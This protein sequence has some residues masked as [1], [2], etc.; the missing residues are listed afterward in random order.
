MELTLL[1]SVR[2]YTD[3]NGVIAFLEPHLMGREV[4]FEVHSHG[5]QLPKLL[6][7]EE[8]V[9]LNVRRGGKAVIRIRRINIAE[10]LYRLTGEGI[11]RDSV[12]LGLPVP[13]R[14]PLLNAQVMGTD[15]PITA[16]YRGKLFW[17]F[18]DTNGVNRLNLAG[19]VATSELPGRGGLDPSKG[20][21]LTFFVD[22][23]GFS[24][25][26]FPFA[27]GKELV[28]PE[29]PMALRDPGGVERLVMLY[30]RG[31]GM[32]KAFL[33]KK[34]GSVGV[35]VKDLTTGAETA[36]ASVPAQVPMTMPEISK[37]GSKVAYAVFESGKRTM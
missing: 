3:S 4:F 8:G 7:G 17:F 32:G 14:E 13:L 26:M 33:S 28:W 22:G 16:I 2:Y 37:D 15:G 19:A 35:W 34:S 11:Y 18:G 24:K 27:E 30:D 5:Y 12:L 25:A 31:A 36:V 6:D 21:D 9:R 23:K 10:R 1:N 20:V 29:G